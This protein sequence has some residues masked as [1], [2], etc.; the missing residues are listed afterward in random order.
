MFRYATQ[1]NTTLRF[2]PLLPPQHLAA[3]YSVKH[4]YTTSLPFHFAPRMLSYSSASL[5]TL[6]FLQ[7]CNILSSFYP[8]I[9]RLLIPFSLI[10]SVRCRYTSSSAR[11]IK[12]VMPLSPAISH[13]E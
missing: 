13:P 4:L 8:S 3:Q 10:R 12:A 6:Q 2:R 11:F 1:P 5:Q 9:R 7:L